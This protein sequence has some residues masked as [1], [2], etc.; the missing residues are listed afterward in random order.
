MPK[1]SKSMCDWYWCLNDFWTFLKALLLFTVLTELIIFTAFARV[2]IIFMLKNNTCIYF[3]CVFQKCCNHLHLPAKLTLALLIVDQLIRTCFIQFLIYFLQFYSKLKPK[4]LKR[5]WQIKLSWK[6]CCSWQILLSTNL[7]E[8]ENWQ[9][10][11]D[12]AIKKES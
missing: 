8:E 11:R 12:L 6:V 10:L 4:I 3:I 5:I 2:T 1:N 7:K 9:M